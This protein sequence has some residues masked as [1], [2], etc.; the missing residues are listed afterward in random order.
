[1][2]NEPPSDCPQCGGHRVEHFLVNRGTTSIT[3]CAECGAY[4]R[5][6]VE[7]VDHPAWDV[8]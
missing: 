8:P 7:L 1:M 4:S 3:A 5:T 2:T 6:P